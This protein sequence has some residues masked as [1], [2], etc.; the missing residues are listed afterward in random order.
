MNM[1]RF[2]I[3]L[4]ILFIAWW[5]WDSRCYDLDLEQQQNKEVVEWQNKSLR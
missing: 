3:V 4:I 1:I 2:I 5:L